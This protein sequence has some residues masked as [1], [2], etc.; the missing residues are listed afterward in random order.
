MSRDIP[1]AS[2]PQIPVSELVKYN[3]LPTLF[4]FIHPAAS[5]PSEKLQLTEQGIDQE[6]EKKFFSN[7]MYIGRGQNV[8]SK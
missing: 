6:I 8:N 7:L 5:K 4:C 2:V 3:F 1:T